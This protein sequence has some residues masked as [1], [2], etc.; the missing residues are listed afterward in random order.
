MPMI[1]R[2]VHLTDRQA[3]WLDAEASR[4]KT[5]PGDVLRRTLDEYLDRVEAQLKEEQK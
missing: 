1:R 4:L 5:S 2:V 3:E